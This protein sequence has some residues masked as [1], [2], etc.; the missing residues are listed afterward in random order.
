MK[1]TIALHT[2]SPELGITLVDK[3]GHKK[4]QIWNLGRNLGKELHQILTDFINPLTWQDFEFIGVAKGPGSFTSTRIGVV[5]ARTIAQQLNIPVYGISTLKSL[6]WQ[7]GQRHRAEIMLVQMRANNEEVFGGIYK[8]KNKANFSVVVGDKIYKND[9]WKNIIKE[10]EKQYGEDLL[11]VVSPQ[12]LGE[13]SDSV[14]SLARLKYEQ[15]CLNRVFSSWEG[16][17]PFYQ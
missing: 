16:L 13:N 10:Y 2:T 6:A 3:E 1:A 4:S 14:L 7:E 12:N 15:E 5:T 11:V 8:L 9:D 17:I